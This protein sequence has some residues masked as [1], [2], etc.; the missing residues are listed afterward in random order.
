[1]IDL[2]VRRAKPADRGGAVVVLARAFHNDPM[3]RIA[4]PDPLR[5]A[6]GLL[7]VMAAGVDDALRHGEVWVARR[8]AATLGAAVWY[9]PGGA[10][11]GP[12]RSGRQVARLFP[13][14]IATGARIPAMLR[15]LRAIEHARPDPPY[16]YL[17]ILGVDPAFQRRGI[18]DALLAPLLRRCDDEMTTAHLETHK[19]DNVGWYARSGFAT[20]DRIEVRGLPPVWTMRRAPR[21]PDAV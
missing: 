1:M 14:G 19:Y 8:D 16:Y 20:A 12:L 18:G 6:R 3:F 17:E 7:R 15:L 4:M 5:Q 21:C 11:R 10:E 9:P 2:E 13:N